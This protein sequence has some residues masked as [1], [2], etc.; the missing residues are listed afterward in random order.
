MITLDL[1]H[2][3][4]GDVVHDRAQAAQAALATVRA[5]YPVTCARFVHNDVTVEVWPDDTVTS[6][7]DRYR[8]RL[9]TYVP[10][11]RAIT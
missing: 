5:H 10:R 8:D 7:V 1:G 6:V 2:S 3:M 9:D 4:P 11:H